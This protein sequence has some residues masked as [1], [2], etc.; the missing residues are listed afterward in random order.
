MEKTI[1]FSKS[2]KGLREAIGKTRI[3]SR[4]Q[5]NLLKEIDGKATFGELI[6]R[7][8]QDWSE[9]ELQQGLDDLVNEGFIHPVILEVRSTLAPARRF[10]P[11]TPEVQKAAAPS[12]DDS[13]ENLDF[14]ALLPAA[15]SPTV[16]KM[17]AE[18]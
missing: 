12:E 1:I 15:G 6:G 10:P 2:A 4:S 8:S 9:S 11:R 14:T 18:A 17:A 7:L 5:R 13:L 3:L 16:K